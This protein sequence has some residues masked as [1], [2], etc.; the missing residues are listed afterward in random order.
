M[1]CLIYLTRTLSEAGVRLA[2]KMQVDPR[3]SVGVTYTAAVPVGTCSSSCVLQ[4]L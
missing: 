2:Q 1:L 4:Q 3:I